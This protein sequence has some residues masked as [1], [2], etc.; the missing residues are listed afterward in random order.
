MSFTIITATQ[1][2]NQMNAEIAAAAQEQSAVS[3]DISVRVNEVNEHTG[4]LAQAS[5][6]NKLV[7]KV[8]NDK[9]DRLE[10]LVGQFRL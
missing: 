8:L 3:A 10:K 5:A 4:Q 2:I 9:T 1:T 7:C 6:D